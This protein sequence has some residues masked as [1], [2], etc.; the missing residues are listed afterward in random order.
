MA[1]K[2]TDCWLEGTRAFLAA[3]AKASNPYPC[4]MSREAWDEG[5][6]DAAILADLKSFGKE[7]A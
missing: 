2:Y 1:K 5:W 7:A 6:D 3:E 4:G